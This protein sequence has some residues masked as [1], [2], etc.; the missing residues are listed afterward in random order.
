VD[1]FD[2]PN[3]L[4]FSPDEAILYVNDSVLRHIRAFDVSLDG[5]I[6]NGRVFAE[7]KL[8][9]AGVPDGMKVD[10]Q[11]NV[12]CTGPGGIWIMEPGGK[13]LG[14]ILM[15]ELPA[16]FAWGDS[17]WKT[18]YITART[19]IYRLELAVQGIAVC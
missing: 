19:S 15:P 7:M 1:D 13:S 5:S 9:E 2:L 11:G 18:L 10:L 16:N 6:S 4:A 14:R 3:G 17:D 12:Y 8:P